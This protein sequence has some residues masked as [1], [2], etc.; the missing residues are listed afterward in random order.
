[1]TT[2]SRPSSSVSK[3]H[4]SLGFSRI[5]VG[6]T[7]LR[8][9]HLAALNRHWTVTTDAAWREEVSR[10]TQSEQTSLDLADRPTILIVD[11]DP[12]TRALYREIFPAHAYAIEECD[13]GAEALG[14]AICRL[15][16]LIINETQIRRIDGIAL[17]KLLRADVAT[18]E[19]PI[20]IVTAA[21]TCDRMRA[22]RA[23]A[24]AVVGKP[25]E[26]QALVTTVRDILASRVP[27]RADESADTASIATSGPARL[28]LS[29]ALHRHKTTMPDSPPP[30]L[31]CPGCDAQLVYQH[32]Y[33]GGV[34]QRSVEQWD[35][36]ACSRCGVFQY[37]H[38]TRVLKPTR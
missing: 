17:S 12:D 6:E 15:P 5:P 22:S 20:V 36:L 14:R 38:R 10:G 21:N 16:D 26:L 9:W 34:N 3:S 32:S 33:L 25:F 30:S 29:H 35:Y 23:G 13:D 1:M 27:L 18:R 11:T 37:R 24:T 8:H 28:P 2:A 4:R 7:S 19:I 31:R